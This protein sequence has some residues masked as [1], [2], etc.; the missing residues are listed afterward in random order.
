M[1]TDRPYKRR[2]PPADVVDDFARNTGRQFAPE[3]VTAF[4]G[5]MLKELTG[6]SKDKRFRR[7][8]GRDYMETEGLSTLIASTLNRLSPT[9]A[10][11]AIA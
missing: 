5:G 10:A 9:S 11:T 8:L 4:L 6:E 2:R 1:T 3:L 7:L